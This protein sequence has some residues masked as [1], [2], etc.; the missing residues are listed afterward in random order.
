M[1]AP[2]LPPNRGAARHLD[3]ITMEYARDLICDYPR[4]L[5]GGA[6]RAY[7]GALLDRVT[8]YGGRWIAREVGV[9]HPAMSRQ[10]LE[11]Q[12]A[13]ALEGKSAK[14]LTRCGT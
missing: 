13:K 11:R 1:S 12:I 14:E 2:Y 7:V 4:N 6:L 8:L 9:R 10:R 5:T 3:S